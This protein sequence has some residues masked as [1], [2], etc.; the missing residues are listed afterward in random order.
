MGDNKKPFIKHL[1]KS[2][3]SIVNNNENFISLP[4]NDNKIRFPNM[5]TLNAISRNFDNDL[6]EIYKYKLTNKYNKNILLKTDSKYFMNDKKYKLISKKIKK[7]NSNL[8]INNYKINKEKKE[9]DKTDYSTILKYLE[10]WDKEHCYQNKD[11]GSTSLLYKNLINYYKN[12]NLINEEKNLNTIDNMLKIKPGF[13]QFLY[14]G[15]FNQ[16]KLLKDLIMRTPSNNN[17]NKVNNDNKNENENNNNTIHLYNNSNSNKIKKKN[18]DVFIKLLNKKKEDKKNNDFYPNKIFKEKIKYEKDLHQKLLF[19]NNLLFNKK[20]MKEE[21]KKLLDLIYEE[22]NKLI[23]SYNEKFNKDIKQYWL[24][25]DEYDYSY[26]KRIEILNPNI[27]ININKEQLS[28]RKSLSNKINFFSSH[29]KNIENLKNN[30]ISSLNTEMIIKQKQLKNEYIEKFK[31]YNK[32]KD[33][34]ENDIKIINNELGYYKHVNDELL[35]EYKT[36]YMDILKKGEDIRRDGLLWVVKNLIELKIN[37]E[38][39]HFPKYLTHEQIDYL[40]NLAI[41]ILEENELKI[42]ISILKKR[43]SNEIIND[44]IQR[45][46]LV[47]S[48]MKDKDNNTNS[49]FNKKEGNEL[50]KRFYKIYKNN[51]KALKFNL[52]KNEEDIKIKNILIQIK[53]GLYSIGDNLSPKKTNFIND[54]KIS[55]LNAF[56]GKTKDKDLFNLILSIRNR[57]ID[58]N[59]LK[60]KIIQKEKENYLDSLKFIGNNSYF[61]KKPIKEIIKK[62]LFG[63]DQIEN[64]K[65]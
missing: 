23:V 40:K 18:E 12:N 1:I 34:L 55:I 21:K 47:D 3:N 65:N 5:K 29:I 64:E 30:K 60:N 41:I 24:R 59:I 52:D 7:Y 11:K 20:F 33:I 16:N 57:L 35:R 58:L 63:I 48:L 62:A 56:M 53:K 43:Q 51:Q 22:K 50:I 26:K 28:K 25:Y 15:Y 4:N 54:N 14:N 36:Y 31:N 17:K 38:Y 8:N 19:I 32:E 44:N 9:E 27:N 45:M 49:S 39:Q 42:I 2:D 61:D 6:N 37:L 13:L 46:N 10:K